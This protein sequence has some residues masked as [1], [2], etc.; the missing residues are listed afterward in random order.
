MIEGRETT[1]WTPNRIV[2]LVI[3]I[4]FTLL[5]LAGLFLTSTMTPRSLLGFDVDLVHNLIHLIAGLIGL[6][7]AF[8]GWARRFNQI[9]GI[10]FILFGLAGLV[11]PGLY[12]GKLLLGLTHANAADH[13]L[14]LVAGLIAAAVGFLVTGY[15][16]RPTA[17]TT[18]TTRTR[19]Y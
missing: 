19:S 7:A 6:A 15:A 5:G 3:G 10:V 9:F 12:F 16:T 13:A 2:A 17:T 4:V 18:T 1:D 11:Y 8:G 14:H